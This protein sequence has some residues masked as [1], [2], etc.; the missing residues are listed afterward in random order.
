MRHSIPN[1]INALSTADGDETQRSGVEKF[2][3]TKA[4]GFLLPF[5]L[6]LCMHASPTEAR[7]YHRTPREDVC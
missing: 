2:Q 6:P 1:R 5:L 7:V 3:K 4:L